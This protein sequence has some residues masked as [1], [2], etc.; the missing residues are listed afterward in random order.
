MI[1]TYEKFMR[2]LRLEIESLH[3]EIEIILK[4]LDER[5]ANHEIT[6]YVHN[7]N[8][9]ILRNELLG[10]EDFLRTEF[11]V[12]ERGEATLDDVVNEVRGYLR[13]RLNE[14]DYVPALYELM[15][16]RIEKIVTYLSQTVPAGR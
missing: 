7:E 14:R 15:N 4:S 12:S 10:L 13:K 8:G 16:R 3:D 1:S 11:D 5:L 2:L 6:D 9:A